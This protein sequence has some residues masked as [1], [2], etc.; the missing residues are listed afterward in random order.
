MNSAKR[1]SNQ[2]IK[3]N[4]KQKKKVTDTGFNK[5]KLIIPAICAV[6]VL[7][8]IVMV[9]WENLHPKLIYTVNG[10]KVYLSDM[11]FDI[12]MT[13]STGEYMNSM[14]QQNYGSDYWSVENEDGITNAELLKD[15]TL[16][17]SMQ[18]DMMYKEA[19]EKGYALTEEE[20]KKAEDDSKSAFTQLTADVKNKTGLSQAKI[21]DYYKKKTLADRYKK[22]WIDTFA[23]DDEAITAGVKKEDFRQYDIQYYYIPYTKADAKGQQVAMTADEKSAAVAELKAS[24]NDIVGLPD[25]TT[26]VASTDNAAASADTAATP[27]PVPVGPTAPPDSNIKYTSTN[28]VETDEKTFDPELLTAIK[29]MKNDDISEDVVEDSKGCYL[30]KMIN[31]DDTESYITQCQTA[32]SDAENEEFDK[33]IDNLEVEKYLIE[34]NDDEWDKV[35]FGNVT[36]AK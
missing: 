29:S 27:S 16:T 8:L 26:Y 14:Y 36:I 23:I 2:T 20:T 3:S 1:V 35:D 28:F 11:M 7:F 15:N 30:I 9:C 17:S 31:N 18:R 6:V 13:E 34:V 5:T 12:Y 21:L 25:F 4:K 10:E 22:D 33:Q 19:G 24:Y 32:I